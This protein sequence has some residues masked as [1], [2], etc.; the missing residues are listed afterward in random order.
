MERIL[1]CIWDFF[2][3]QNL[4]EGWKIWA[5]R[6]VSFPKWTWMCA[7]K[8][9]TL[10]STQLEILHKSETLNVESE[11]LTKAGGRRRGAGARKA[12][13]EAAISSSFLS[14]R[15]ACRAGLDPSINAHKEPEACLFDKNVLFLL[16]CYY[17]WQLLV[18]EFLHAPVLRGT[19]EKPPE[20]F[21]VSV[22][23]RKQAPHGRC[24][25][26]FSDASQRKKF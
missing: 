8:W 23:V 1:D 4:E 22:V 5:Q 25:V 14:R 3:T 20:R 13:G 10:I 24:H 21:N 2:E 15:P 19:V 6:F 12:G 26:W 18:H 9:L 7:F 17:A 11:H 16:P